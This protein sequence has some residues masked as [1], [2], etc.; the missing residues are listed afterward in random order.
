MAKIYFQLSEVLPLIEHSEQAPAQRV[1][2]THLFDKK[3]WKEGT[4]KP[5]DGF[6][7]EGDVD[8]SKIEQNV[9]LVKDD[10]IYL[11]SNGNPGLL[12]EEG[13]HKVTYAKNCNP[14]TDADCWETA[15]ALVGG[16]DFGEALPIAMFRQAINDR[17]GAKQVVI[18]LLKT[19]IRV[20]AK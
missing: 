2:M 3:Y 8:V 17:P 11:M 1:S 16:D 19:R 12:L 13:R 15:R 6:V 14:K 5:S 10:G 7:K 18:T 4:P 9:L 20:E